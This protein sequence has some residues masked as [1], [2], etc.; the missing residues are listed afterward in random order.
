MEG[1]VEDPVRPFAGG[2]GGNSDWLEV[3]QPDRQGSSSQGVF[4][5]LLEFCYC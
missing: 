3:A 1:A 4:H 2:G 5:N